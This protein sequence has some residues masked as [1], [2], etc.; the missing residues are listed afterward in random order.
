MIGVPRASDFVVHIP[1]N[2]IYESIKEKYKDFFDEKNFLF[3]NITDYINSTVM[4]ANFPA[5]KLNSNNSQIK[6]YNAEKIEHR[7]G[8]HSSQKFDKKIK[9]NFQLKTSYLNWFI[10]HD[11]LCD[12]NDNVNGD[13]INNRVVGNDTFLPDISV[14]MLDEDGNIS[15][16]RILK[17]IVPDSMDDITLIKSE[18]KIN[19]KEFSVTFKYSD[20]MIKHNSLDVGGKF[21]K[22]YSY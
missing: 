1:D 17:N 13:K 19:K 16:E 3:Q 10:W 7:S 2:F 9:I 18:S 14:F 11:L 8:M 6:G 12:Y 21:K 5:P 4:S 20:W 15:H 22:E